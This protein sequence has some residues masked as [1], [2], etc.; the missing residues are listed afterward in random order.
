MTLLPVILSSIGP[1]VDWPR[2]R[3]ETKASPFWTRWGS[4]IVRRRVLA[5]G[6]AAVILVGLAIP[7]LSLQ[8][9]QAS[10]N[11]LATAGPAV[12]GLH[13]LD[14]AGVPRGALTPMVVLTTSQGQSAVVQR[15]R[16]VTGLVDA[17]ATIDAGTRRRGQHSSSPC[18]GRRHRT[19]T[20][21]TLSARHAAPSPGRLSRLVSAE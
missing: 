10:S 9:G 21:S 3:K 15:L 12:D 14:G 6:A 20:P 17:T 19:R 4:L 8:I 18:H 7:F 11:S 13:V 5:V 1:R 2:I 16:S